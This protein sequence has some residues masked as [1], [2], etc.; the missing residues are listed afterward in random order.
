MHTLLF[1]G[2]AVVALLLGWIAIW[3][4]K[5]RVVRWAAVLL[6]VLLVGG[7]YPAYVELLSRPKD[8]SEEW[9]LKNVP[10]ATITGVYIREGIALYLYLMLPGIDEPRSYEF[11]WSDET[12][13]LADSIVK[14]LEEAEGGG[15]EIENPFNFQPS[16]E[17]ER[18]KTVHPLPHE[19]LPSKPQPEAPLQYG[20][21]FDL[22]AGMSQEGLICKDAEAGESVFDQLP[23]SRGASDLIWALIEAKKCTYVEFIVA[24]D[25]TPLGTIEMATPWG[26][27]LVIDMYNDKGVYK[28]I[29]R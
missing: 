14:A 3:S 22:V 26:E 17:R 20:I 5:G 1:V 24:P 16:L 10:T 27:P 7:S 28:F 21:S 6:T 15:V 11:P 23:R 4:Q 18:S 29:Q 25:M 2:V 13:E 12:R 8:V 19:R 9:Y